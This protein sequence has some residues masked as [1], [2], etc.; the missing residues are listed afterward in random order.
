MHIVYPKVVY[1]NGHYHCS[2]CAK[3]Y[4]RDTNSCAEC[5][6]K[7]TDH[8]DKRNN[9]AMK[10]T[11]FDKCDQATEVALTIKNMEANGSLN[12]PQVR[13]YARIKMAEIKNNPP[14]VIDYQVHGHPNFDKDFKHPAFTVREDDE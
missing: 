1:V 11:H 9:R 14:P 13:E 7:M 5:L 3:E 10:K 4:D 6:Q 2:V 8:I 12:T